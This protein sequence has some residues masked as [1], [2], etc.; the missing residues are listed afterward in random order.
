MNQ[1]QCRLLSLLAFTWQLQNEMLG[2]LVNWVLFSCF[3]FVLQEAEEDLAPIAVSGIAVTVDF[4]P[5]LFRIFLMSI[6]K[7]E[8]S[9]GFGVFFKEKLEELQEEK[10]RVVGQKEASDDENRKKVNSKFLF[11][12]KKKGTCRFTYEN[13]SRSFRT[14]PGVL[15]RGWLGVTWSIS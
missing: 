6:N 8:K 10:Q 4:Y 9:L 1:D 14:F 11:V 15:G 5:L 2:N 12:W 7:K 13:E 3:T